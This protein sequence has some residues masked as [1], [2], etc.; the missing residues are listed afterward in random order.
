MNR[1]RSAITRLFHN[2]DGQDLIEY[3][4]LGSLIAVV[5]I[6]AVAQLGNV[7]SVAFWQVIAQTV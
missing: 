3:A 6:T 7:I 2:D 1:A 5:A 4:L